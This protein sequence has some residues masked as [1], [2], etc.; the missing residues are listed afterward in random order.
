M[1]DADGFDLVVVTDGRATTLTAQGELDVFSVSRLRAAL[2]RAVAGPPGRILVELSGVSFI[3]AYSMN[4]LIET[5]R[6]AARRGHDFR[7]VSPSA[8]VERVR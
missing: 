4:V 2:S 8:I 6:V 3:D 5:A 1:D 7:I